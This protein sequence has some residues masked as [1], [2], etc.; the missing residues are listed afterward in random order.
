MGKAIQEIV[1]SPEIK[2]E[3]LKMREA[4]ILSEEDEESRY[5]YWVLLAA[6][7]EIDHLRPKFTNKL[8]KLQLIDLDVHFALFTLVYLATI[9]L[10]CKVIKLYSR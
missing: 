5:D 6:N 9:I 3:V 7:G 4:I 1:N 2:E 8:L 10:S